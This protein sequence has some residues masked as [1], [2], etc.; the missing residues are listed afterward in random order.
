MLNVFRREG[1]VIR[2]TW[3]SEL[4][5]EEPEPGQD[6][7]HGDTIDPLWNLFDLTPAGRGTDWHPALSYS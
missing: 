3:G 6:M 1:G 7:R 5:Y 4:L 2:H